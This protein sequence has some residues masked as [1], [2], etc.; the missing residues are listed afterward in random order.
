MMDRGVAIMYYTVQ[1]VP[2]PVHVPVPAPAPASVPVPVPASVPVPVPWIILFYCAN[3]NI[4][5]YYVIGT[6]S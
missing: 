3:I 6:L 1:L 5:H 2:V 4:S